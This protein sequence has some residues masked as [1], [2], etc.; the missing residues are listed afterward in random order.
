LSLVLV[1]WAILLL[2][3]FLRRLGKEGELVGQISGVVFA[4]CWACSG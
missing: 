4:G 3:Y 2:F 1:P